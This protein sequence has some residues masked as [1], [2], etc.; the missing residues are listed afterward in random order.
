LG[1]DRYE[2]SGNM[3]TDAGGTIVGM[4][5]TGRSFVWLLQ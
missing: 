5:D 3:A 1:R 2:S 4:D